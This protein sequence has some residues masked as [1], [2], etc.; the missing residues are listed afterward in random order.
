MLSKKV[1][2]VAEEY[3]KYLGRNENTSEYS[4]RS[5]YRNHIDPLY[6]SR[7]IKSIKKQDIRKL[8]LYMLE[9]KH[10][11]IP[12]ASI[13]INNV[14]NLFN[15][16]MN[17]A[18]D[19]GYLKLNPCANLSVI[20]I[21]KVNDNNAFWTNEEFC[22]AIEYEHDLMWYTYLVISYLTGMRKGEVRGLK[23]KD[24]D[25]KHNIINI[26]R[27]VNDKRMYKES[28]KN[29]EWVIDGRKNGK[30]HQILMDEN[31]KRLLLQLLDQC[32]QND[33][34]NLYIFGGK[35]PVGQNSPKRHL[36][37]I[38]E[39]AGLPYI[40]VHGLRHSHVSFL[41]DKGLN[42][43]EIAERIG[44][45]VEMVLKVYGHL[46]PNPQKNIVKVINENL[47]FDFEG[48]KSN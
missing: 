23:W 2:D 11:G 8:Q 41:I 6:G 43:Y 24:V 1:K 33:Y 21:V 36:D 26:R 38:A 34:K 28:D 18:V 14:T 10:N 27:H 30:E 9:K 16:I 17:Y 22:E 3:F 48:Q 47:Y 32:D 35:K 5:T 45:T 13:T 25:F 20:K 19:W 39:E 40:K 37:K 12:Y 29:K 31:T 44:D 4:L 46:F 15:M 42:A 7:K